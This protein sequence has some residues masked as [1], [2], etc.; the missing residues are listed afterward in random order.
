MKRIRYA[1]LIMSILSSFMGGCASRTVDEQD[2]I[3][4]VTEPLQM[5]LTN[6][7]LIHI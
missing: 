5:Q 3:V 1:L 2:A 4:T 7:S 6:L